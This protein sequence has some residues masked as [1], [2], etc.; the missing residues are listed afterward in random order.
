MCNGREAVT[1]SRTKIV[2]WERSFDGLGAFSIDGTF[3]AGRISYKHLS[4]SGLYAAT[5]VCASVDNLIRFLASMGDVYLVASDLDFSD[6]SIVE[7][8]ASCTG[9]LVAICVVRVCLNVDDVATIYRENRLGS[10]S[11]RGRW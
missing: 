10:G 6:C 9:I 1:A 2:E 8:T 3:R 5:T 4:A 7:I 11:W